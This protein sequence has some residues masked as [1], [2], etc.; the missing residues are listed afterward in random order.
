MSQRALWQL[1]ERTRNVNVGDRKKKS[2][3]LPRRP[4]VQPSERKRGREEERPEVGDVPPRGR[5]ALLRPDQ[6]QP[7]RAA[8]PHS[9]CFVHSADR[10]CKPARA[11]RSHSWTR[12]HTKTNAL[13]CSPSAPTQFKGCKRVIPHQP[14][15]AVYCIVNPCCDIRAPKRS[16]ARLGEERQ[17]GGMNSH[18]GMGDQPD[19][20]HGGSLFIGGYRPFFVAIEHQS[21]LEAG[22]ARSQ[23][24]AAAE[25]RRSAVRGCNSHHRKEVTLSRTKRSQRPQC[26]SVAR[27]LVRQDGVWPLSHT[28]NRRWAAAQKWRCRVQAEL[29]GAGLDVRTPVGARI[30]AA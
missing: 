21:G 23:G 18:E 5:T 7:A 8:S 29:M 4:A 24:R 22:R 11:T 19:G 2:D 25:W 1:R 12:H 27:A 6:P 14:L 30:R 26:W 28:V 20:L 17:E 16:S 3:A 10:W 15:C 9:I 13:I